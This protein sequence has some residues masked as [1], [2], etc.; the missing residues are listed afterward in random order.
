M[1]K[2][3]I[4]KIRGLIC[5]GMGHRW[6]EWHTYT[7]ECIK[8]RECLRCNEIQKTVNHHW[9]DW[10]ESIKEKCKE[11]RQCLMDGTIEE[12]D[13]HNWVFESSENVV[14][15]Q[16]HNFEREVGTPPI[17]TDRTVMT[18][19]RYQCSKCQ[20]FKTLEGNTFTDRVPWDGE[21]LR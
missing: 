7:Q 18:V 3:V 6:T 1:L 16:S 10:Q 11:I 4:Q 19:E 12:R 20:K 17:S 9:G 8:A 21:S 5:R 15:H 14:I 13:T 2:G